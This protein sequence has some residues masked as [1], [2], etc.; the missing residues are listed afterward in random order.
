MWIL[1]I[2]PEGNLMSMVGPPDL[3]I[4]LIPIVVSSGSRTSLPG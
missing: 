3:E 2:S 4:G 1:R